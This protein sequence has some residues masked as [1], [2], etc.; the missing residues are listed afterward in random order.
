MIADEPAARAWVEARA[1]CTP[2]IMAGLEQFVAMLTAENHHQNLVSERSLADIWRRHIADSAQLLDHVPRETSG[3][4]LDLGTGAGFPGLVVALLAPARE[5]ILT[6]S[7]PRRCAWLEQC[8]HALELP[9]VRVVPARVERAALP[10]CAVVSARAFAPLPA[11]FKLSA[12]LST[13][14]TLWLLPKGRQAAQELNDLTGWRHMFHVER[15]ITDP[16]AGII[17]GRLLGPATARQ[18][19]HAR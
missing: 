10:A 5:V 18:T 2:A 9:N 14:E 1:E 11:L 8:R 13:P 17:T 16:E 6:D 19:G 7:R 15:S 12:H 4:W 3:C